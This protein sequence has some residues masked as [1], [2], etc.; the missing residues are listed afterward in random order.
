MQR[1]SLSCTRQLML[2]F[3][4]IKLTLQQKVLHGHLNAVEASWRTGSALSA[5]LWFPLSAVIT[6]LN[7]FSLTHTH[8]HTLESLSYIC[9]MKNRFQLP[10]N[11]QLRNADGRTRDSFECS[12]SCRYSCTDTD[13]P[14][15][16]VVEIDTTAVADKYLLWSL[17]HL[18]KLLSVFI[19]PAIYFFCLFFIAIETREA[20][21]G[22]EEGGEQ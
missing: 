10:R 4:W 19:L 5:W 21:E 9:E 7:L 6:H 2:S 13:T 12:Y 1:L 22:S 17:R 14:L 20:E 11:M 15:V 18:W 8:S 3:K 16:V